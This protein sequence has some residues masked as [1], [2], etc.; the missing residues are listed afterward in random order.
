[1]LD[2]LEEQLQRQQGVANSLTW[3]IACAPTRDQ[4]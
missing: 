1:V 4:A 3:I 2:V